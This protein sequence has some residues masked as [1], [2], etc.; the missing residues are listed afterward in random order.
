MFNILGLEYSAEL[1]E[2]TTLLIPEDIPPPITTSRRST[3]RTRLRM[4]YNILVRIIIGLTITNH[5]NGQN[6]SLTFL[7]EGQ[8]ITYATKS[9]NI[10][11]GVLIKIDFDKDTVETILNSVDNDL[12]GFIRHYPAFAGESGRKYRELITM[13]SVEAMLAAESLAHILKFKSTDAKPTKY[14]C[15]YSHEYLKSTLMTA[16]VSGL[17]GAKE[18]IGAWTLDEI[19]NDPLKDQTIR[20][21]ILGVNELGESWAELSLNMINALDLLANHKFPEDLRGAYKKVDCMTTAA[22]QEAVEVNQCWKTVDGL[23]CSVE[24]IEPLITVNAIKMHTIS[25]DNIR[26]MP[27]NDEELFIRTMEQKRELSYLDCENYV[28]NR[29]KIP[30]CEK[31]QINKY[32]EEALNA[33]HVKNII[34]NCNFSREANPQV[35]LR[36]LNEGILIQGGDVTVSRKVNNELVKVSD[37][38]P[39]LVYSPTDIIVKQHEE[40]WEV[41]AA[42]T[43]IQFKVIKTALTQEDIDNLKS[44]MNWL[45][46][47]E[48]FD[49]ETTGQLLLAVITVIGVPLTACGIGIG[50]KNKKI[51]KTLMSMIT[52]HSKGKKKKSKKER[53][54]EN[55]MALQKLVTPSMV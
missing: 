7:T 52:E 27:E 1:K 45:E 28:F 33:K 43:G 4:M 26:I 18:K 6:E 16:Q 39:I 53:Y 51:I 23:Y 24:I 3:L 10:E 41:V 42:N 55:K 49:I 40:T 38:T 11:I 15:E 44:R 34:S 30:V 17:L 32:C 37:E 25:Y 9:R 36:T 46:W 29:E 14:T 20:L 54:Q 12:I 47:K 48:F 8:E 2:S 50:V 13:G 31:R 22:I 35:I 21:F 5:A 19:A